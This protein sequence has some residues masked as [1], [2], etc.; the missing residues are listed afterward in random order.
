MN[1]THLAAVVAC[2]VVSSGTPGSAQE[3]ELHSAR[4]LCLKVSPA[5]AAEFES[6]VRE[7][8]IPAEKERIAAGESVG[9]DLLRAV[10]PAGSACR[11]DYLVIFHYGLLA[12]AEPG[13][14][15]ADYLS[16]AGIDPQP[17]MAKW[18]QQV[19]QVGSEWWWW[20]ERVGPAWPKGSYVNIAQWRTKANGFGHFVELER[21]YFKPLAEAWREEGAKFSWDIVGLWQPGGESVG[22]NGMTINVYH[23]WETMRG[24]LQEVFGRIWPKVFP[25]LDGTMI[26]DLKQSVRSQHAS[27]IYRVVETTTE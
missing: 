3:Q 9:F 17:V 6:L 18:S 10:V 23:D 1:R 13:D 22:Y 4:V 26:E 14:N 24:W 8:G 27:A 19:E 7:A 16:R 15:V 5:D 12:E 21:S 11:C 20:V 2:L 25:G